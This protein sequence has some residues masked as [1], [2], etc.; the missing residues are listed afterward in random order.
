MVG[1]KMYAEIQKR[2][3]MGYS[4]R[5]CARELEI[6]KKTVS[7]YWEMS[8]E[9]YAQS[10]IDAKRRTR[11]L[12]QYRDFIVSRLEE[13]PEIT[14]FYDA[15]TDEPIAFHSIRYGKGNHVPLPS[16]ADRFRGNKYETLKSKVL[17]RFD[18]LHGAGEYIDG[19]I[20]KYPRYTRDQLSII[21]KAQEIYTKPELQH[22][23]GYC[24]QRDLVSANDFRDTLEYFRQA[25]ASVPLRA[26]TLPVQYSVVRAEIRPLK[27]YSLACGAGGGDSL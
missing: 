14:T 1:T 22:A 7:K 12:D 8:E 27:V 17:E 13:R 9:K 26:V 3:A 16:N 10:V 15:E 6:D 23:L 25:G 21:S 18:G 2:R 5:R 24:I 11:I 4:K 19:I 20:R